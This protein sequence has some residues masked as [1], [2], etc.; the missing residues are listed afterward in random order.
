MDI[1]ALLMQSL[2]LLGLGMGAVFIILTLL[3]VIISIV[4]K[5]VPVE[6]S[7]PPALPTQGIDPAH[8]AAISAAVHQYR[9][10]R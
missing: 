10:N 8:V 9:K 3:I 6:V 7:P 2:Q 4:S 1:D 5:I